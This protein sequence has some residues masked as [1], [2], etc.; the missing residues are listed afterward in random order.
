M[1]A[2]WRGAGLAHRLLDRRRRTRAGRRR[3]ATPGAVERHPLRAR[4]P[5]LRAARL[6][7]G[8]AIRVLND[9]SNSLEFGYAKPVNSVAVL[10]AAAAASAER[11]LAEVLMACVADGASVSFLPPLAPD[12]A[13]AFWRRQASEV[14]RVGGC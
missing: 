2:P 5:V 11:C 10:D 8:R 7:A 13:R 3:D 4:A 9:L 1:L 12:V 14:A 6:R